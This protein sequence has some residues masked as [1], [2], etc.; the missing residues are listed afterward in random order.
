MLLTLTL[1]VLALWLEFVWFVDPDAF[2]TQT[3]SAQEA[4]PSSSPRHYF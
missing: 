2:R 1:M 3:Y 4:S